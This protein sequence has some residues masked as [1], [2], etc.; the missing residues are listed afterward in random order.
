MNHRNCLS[1]IALSFIGIGACTSSLHRAPFGYAEPVADWDGVRN[2]SRDGNVYFAGQPTED[3]L[4]EAV[5][6]DIKVV[7]NLRGDQE[8]ASKVDFDEP[9]MVEKLG[10]DYVSIPITP[11]SLSVADADRLHEIL[12][13]TRGPV[14]IHCASANRVGALWALY[15]HRHRG[16]G[17]DTAIDLG[18]KAG[19]RSAGLIEKLKTIATGD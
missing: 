12:S 5:R 3:A 17:L 11:K 6:R 14:L 13:G 18:R 1:V 9:A 2:L 8:M 15:L 7:V 10:M 19:M 16:V 4:G